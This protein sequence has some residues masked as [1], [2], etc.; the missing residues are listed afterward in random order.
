MIADIFQSDAEE[1]MQ[2]SQND[3]R[4]VI[5]LSAGAGR[6]RDIADSAAEARR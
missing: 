1:S 4:A 5:A 2:G 6:R 3:V